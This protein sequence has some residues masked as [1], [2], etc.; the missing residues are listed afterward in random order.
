MIATIGKHPER[1]GVWCVLVE[2]RPACGGHSY[3]DTGPCF[4]C[5]QA[6]EREPRILSTH[7]TRD[8]AVVSA[9]QIN[10]SAS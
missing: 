5:E 4:D 9:N 6:S 8:G 10:R 1:A 3:Y 7:A 2:E